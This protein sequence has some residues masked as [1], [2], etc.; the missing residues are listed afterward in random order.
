[1][2][3]RPLVPAISYS[4]YNLE[5]SVASVGKSLVSSWNSL[6]IV[7]FETGLLYVALVILELAL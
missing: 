6:V 1:M 3:E 2:L 5:K 7:C 4:L